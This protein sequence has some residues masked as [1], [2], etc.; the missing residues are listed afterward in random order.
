MELTIFGKYGPY[1]KAGGGTS[2]YLLKAG[3][4]KILL[5]A[6]EGSFSRLKS[7][8]D[9]KDIDY[10]FL[11]HSHSDHIC[12]IGI[13]N[14]YY[15]SLS[16]KGVA[17]KKPVVFA[18]KDTIS[19]VGGSPYFEYREI[20]EGL[21]LKE[22][23]LEFTFREV[24]HP[25][26]TF[27]ITISDGKTTFSYSGDTNDCENLRSLFSLG[28]TVLCDGCFLSR[29]YSPLKPHLSVA[30]IAELT[31]KSGNR[32]IITHLNPDYDE[33]DILAEIAAVGGDCIVAKEGATYEI[34]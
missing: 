16:R 19:A 13:Y 4:A 9:P 27:A 23:G 6:G 5:D 24:K 8:I 1:P 14:Y 10:I 32:S 3:Y 11:S 22:K 26:R 34:I 7:A 29:D 2:S 15:E 21:I 28:G 33:K 30:I 18:C 25:V 17:F 31:K 20:S 12:D